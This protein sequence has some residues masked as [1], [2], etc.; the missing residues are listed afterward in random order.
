M[1][2]PMIR[3]TSE[4]VEGA[5]APDA[6]TDEL[7][8]LLG[9]EAVGVV[10]LRHRLHAAPELAHREVETARMIAAALPVPAKTVAGTGLLARV[11]DGPAPPVVVRGEL[12]GLPLVE[13]TGAA[14]A[15]VNGAMHACGHDVHAAALVALARASARMAPRLPAPLVVLLQPSEEAYPSGAL[16]IVEEGV[17]GEDAA[18]VVGAHLHPDIPWEAVGIEPGPIN[19]SS[20]TVTIRVEGVG[21]H[22]AYPHTGRDSILA[23]AA[24]LV[25]LQASIGRELDPLAAGVLSIGRVRA[26]E[27]ENVIPQTAEAKGTL[28][29]LRQEDR[30]R[31]SEVVE[32]VVTATAAAHG[33][34][35]V[36]EIARG[37]PA[38]VNDER[39]VSAARGA[40]ELIGLEV[41]PAWRSLG[42][43]DFSFYGAVAPIA[44][45]FV[46]LRDAPGFSP[47]ALHHPEFLP[48]D[49]AILA[50]ARAQA[51]LYLG[52][53]GLP[54]AS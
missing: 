16:R 20:D 37:A 22:A 13:R 21:A 24:T 51:A 48:P 23:L 10:E 31:L 25:S 4:R 3:E 49:A 12:D 52:A 41:A 9:E 43:D 28:R 2:P 18:A 39:V 53:A 15:S 1:I 5:P 36:V 19:A 42:A 17:L 26:G 7:L 14:F 35:G 33:C 29:T 6:V 38:L 44:M 47:R 54:P 45:M 32:R 34:E 46:G 30:E 27:T 11:G 50:V 8:T 40:A